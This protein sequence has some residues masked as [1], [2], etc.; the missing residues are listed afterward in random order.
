MKTQSLSMTCVWRQHPW[1]GPLGHENDGMYIIL[2]IYI[3]CML[4]RKKTHKQTQFI[5]T[6]LVTYRALE[7]D[8]LDLQSWMIDQLLRGVFYSTAFFG[9]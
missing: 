6:C 8:H 3:L 2:Y 9:G 7:G 5:H 1:V 4:P